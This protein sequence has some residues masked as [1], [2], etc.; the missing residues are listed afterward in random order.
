MSPVHIG[1]ILVSSL[2]H[3]AW[4]ILTR[5]SQ[6]PPYFS[7]LKGVW[8]IALA[9]LA[10]GVTEVSFIHPDVWFWA[11]VSGVLHGLYI[12]C[13]SR[14]YHT[15]DISYVYPIARSAPV[16]VPLFAYVLLGERL[17][18]TTWAAILIIL[19]AIY[20]LHF[21]GHLLQGFRNLF[22]AILHRDLRWAFL[23]LAFVVA[24]SLVD[25]RGME[26][27]FTHFPDQA[28]GNGFAFFFLE[29]VVGFTLYLAYL[30]RVH[31]PRQVWAV[32]RRE[33]RQGLIAGLA[34]VGSYGLICVVLQFE[35]VGAVVSLRQTSVLMVVYWGCW[36]LGEP[37][38]RQRMLAGGLVM[39][40]VILIGLNGP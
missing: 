20:V 5:T 28:V 39:L 21:E 19:L 15:Q 22:D 9:V 34:T 33:W 16:F 31:S 3:A 6:N 29:S 4:N 40:G 1:L 27:F 11:A 7:G 38:G 8:I 36:N 10:G 17:G 26:V 25:K 2:F 14:A 24:Y 13:L 30:L 35:P 18:G 37:L 32:W 12:L 23:T